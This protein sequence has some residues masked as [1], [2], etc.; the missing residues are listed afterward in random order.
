MSPFVE[1]R[2]EGPLARLT[3]K[4]ADKLNALDRA[5]ID[6]LADAARAIEASS[7]TRAA[8]LFGRGQGV[9]RRRRYR[10]LGRPASPRNVARL[11]ARGTSRFR[12][13]GAP[14][15]SA[16][17]RADRARL[18]RRPRIGGRRRHSHRR[19]RDQARPSRDRA[20]HGAGLVGHAEAG[21]P[22]RR[23][24]RA[25]HGVGRR[26]VLGRGGAGSRP[27]R[28]GGRARARASSGRRRSRPISRSGVR[29]RC[30]WSRR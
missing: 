17:R 18:R 7:E 22:L 2:F 29:S 5:M 26:D 27:R 6:A 25:P 20:R 4:R 16:H 9:L 10:R 15:C 12:S 21:A 1:L 30:R 23:L 24:G 14:A 19:A 13:V 28:R 8:V 3:L 11:D